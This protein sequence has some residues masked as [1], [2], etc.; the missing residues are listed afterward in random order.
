MNTLI[1]FVSILASCN[2]GDD[3]GSKGIHLRDDGRIG[4]G[5]GSVGGTG[6]L[7][8]SGGFGGGGFGGGLLGGGGGFGGGLLGGGGGFGG[9]LLGGG[10]GFGG[11]LLGGGGGF[12]GGLLRGIGFGGGGGGFGGGLFGGG[13]LGSY[14]SVE[15]Y[16]TCPYP[17]RADFQQMGPI[18][19]ND[20]D[21]HGSQKCCLNSRYGKRCQIP[22]EYQKS[23]NCNIFFMAPP[24]HQK[25]RACND[26]TICPGSGK[27]CKRFYSGQIDTCTLFS[28]FPSGFGGVG[29]SFGPVGGGGGSF[30]PVGGGSFGP[31]GGS[32]GPVGG[33]LG[34]VGGS[35]GP[36]GGSGVVSP[37]LPVFPQGS[38]KKY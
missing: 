11:G 25:R 14:F 38:K 13:S 27:C 32:F 1:V 36:V 12:G 17:E 9:G 22:M 6:T 31:V 15:K 2:A 34:P 16:G 10:G 5:L 8:G 4:G 28:S 3:Y 18:C 33:S 20:E 37:L 7:G 24:F 21:C 29:G 26:D 30:G 19:S 35:F 23:G